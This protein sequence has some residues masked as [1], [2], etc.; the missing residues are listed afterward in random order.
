MIITL[1]KHLGNETLKTILKRG[2]SVENTNKDVHKLLVAFSAR[3]ACFNRKIRK[4]LMEKMTFGWTLDS[5]LGSTHRG[6][7]HD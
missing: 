2:E 4:A 5:V 6:G 7:E 3:S 1:K